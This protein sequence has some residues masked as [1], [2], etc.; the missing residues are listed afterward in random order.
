M[1]FTVCFSNLTTTMMSSQEIFIRQNTKTKRVT[2][3]EDVPTSDPPPQPHKGEKKSPHLN[4]RPSSRFWDHLSHIWLTRCALREFD[5]RTSQL[6]ISTPK[7][8]S[9]LKGYPVRD[10]KRFARHRGPSLCD[11][12]GVSTY[13]LCL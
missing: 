4:N 12:G 1:L 13:S 2:S 6:V 7:Y 11:L 3:L 9:A 10:L 5:R 8:P